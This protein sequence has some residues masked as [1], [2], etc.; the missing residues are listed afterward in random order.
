MGILGKLGCVAF[1][2]SAIRK[3]YYTNNLKYRKYID[4][5]IEERP[6]LYTDKI[7]H[8]IFG[9][10]IGMYSFPIILYSDISK[11]EM[12]LRDI[13]PFSDDK[14]TKNQKKDINYLSVLLDVHI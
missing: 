8:V 3:L 2:Y 11:I 6:I 4:D 10:I 9:G 5:K 12:Y 14:Y 7:G 13:K 1:S